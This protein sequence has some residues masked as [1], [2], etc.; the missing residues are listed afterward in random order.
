VGHTTRACVPWP[1]EMRGWAAA[2]QST[3]G[4]R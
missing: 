3:M 2:K 1:R 4:A